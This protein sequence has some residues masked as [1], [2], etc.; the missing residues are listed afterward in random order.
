[1]RYNV[2]GRQMADFDLGFIEFLFQTMLDEHFITKVNMAKSLNV[3][4]RTIQYNFQKLENSKQKGGCIACQNLMLYC[5]QNNISIDRLY[6]R[7]LETTWNKKKHLNNPQY[8]D[9]RFNSA[10]FNNCEEGIGMKK[11]GLL[12]W[13]YQYVLKKYMDSDVRSMAVEL[14]LSESLLAD[15]LNN[16]DSMEYT[17]LFEQLLSYCARKGISIDSILKEY[18]ES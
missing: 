17:L 4:H 7:Y 13:I 9:L 6:Q 5:C 2:G 10:Q 14:R 3:T 12:Q 11:P 16:D 1:M 18:S 8:I 15:A